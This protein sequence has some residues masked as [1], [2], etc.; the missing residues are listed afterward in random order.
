MFTFVIVVLLISLIVWLV[1]GPGGFPAPLGE[2]ARIIFWVFLLIMLIM[3]VLSLVG[4]GPRF[5][6]VWW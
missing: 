4:H 6:G 1:S 3:V 5:F 2:I